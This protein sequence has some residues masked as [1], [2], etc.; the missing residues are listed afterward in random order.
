MISDP[1]EVEIEFAVDGR[2]GR[3]DLRTVGWIS[4]VHLLEWSLSDCYVVPVS[5]VT[6][7]RL[8]TSGTCAAANNRKRAALRTAD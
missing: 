8:R 1:V 6:G 3:G 7:G 4:Q 5:L 2:H